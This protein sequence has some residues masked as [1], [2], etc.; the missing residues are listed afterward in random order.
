MICD[1]GSKLVGRQNI[2]DSIEMLQCSE[3]IP[4]GEPEPF[5]SALVPPNLLHLIHIS[6]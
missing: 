4:S 3:N 5:P 1:H 6:H 2:V